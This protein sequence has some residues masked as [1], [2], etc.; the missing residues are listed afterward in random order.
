MS[1]WEIKDITETVGIIAIVGSLIFVGLELRQNSIIARMDA[2]TQF[3]SNISETLREL[4][5]NPELSTLMFDVRVEQR[6]I[7][8]LEPGEVMQ[9]T[10]FYFSVLFNWYGLYQ[11]VEEGILDSEYL[12]T[13]GAAGLFNNST[14]RALWPVMQTT[15]N[16]GFV[17]FFESL[18]WNENN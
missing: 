3:T 13:I 9:I 12:E 4:S 11:S 15:F 8:D 7:Q 2:H 14:F 16:Q 18:S 17:T 10:S 5:L 6:D 1:R